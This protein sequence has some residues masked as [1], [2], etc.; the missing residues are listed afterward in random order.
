MGTLLILSVIVTFVGPTGSISGG[1]ISKPEPQA[2]GIEVIL[3]DGQF[4]YG[5]N[6]LDFDM[7]AFLRANDSPLIEH[8]QALRDWSMYASVNP[9]V[10][11]TLIEM[12]SGLVTG[13]GG[14]DLD[15]PF[16]YPDLDFEAEIEKVTVDLALDFYAH[17]YSY[18]A[19]SNGGGR[20]Q[21]GLVALPLTH[22]GEIQVPGDTPSGS[23]A[24]L[25]RLADMPTRGDAQAMAAESLASEFLATYEALFPGDDPLDDSNDINPASPP[26]STLLQFPF[27]LGA[28][29]WFSGA[30][31]WNG[32]GYGPPYSSMDFG[33]A[34]NICESPPTHLWSVAAAWGVG[35]HPYGYSC[36]YRIS[37]GNG[38]ETSYYH[39][40]NVR[41]DGGADR[42]DPIGTIACET[43]AGGFATGPHVHFS[44]LYNGAYYDLQG[45]HLSGWRIDVGEG[46]YYG[47]F[48]ERDG[49]RLYPYNTVF[50]D[51]IP[52]ETICPRTGSLILYRNSGYDCGGMGQGEGY[53]IPDASGWQN[54][55]PEFDNRASAIN[56]PGGWSTRLYE[57]RFRGGASV[58]IHADHDSFSGDFFDGGA[59]PLNDRVSSL[60]VF[61]NTDCTPG[62]PDVVV[63]YEN[64]G[65]WGAQ[66]AWQ[67]EG[68]FNL[69][70]HLDNQTSSIWVQDGWSAR[71]YAEVNGG[72]QA[73]CLATS[74]GDFA[75]NRY[76]GGQVVDDTASS[77]AIYAQPTCPTPPPPPT[78]MNPAD[79][80]SLQGGE[81][82]RLEWSG[83]PGS[84]EHLVEL[85]GGDGLDTSSGWQGEMS[86]DL[87]ALAGGYYQWRA[88]SRDLY[89]Q[90]SDWSPVRSFI[91]DNP[92]VAPSDFDNDQ[93]TD[94]SLFRPSNGSW[95]ILNRVA[96]HYGLPGDIPVAADYNGDGQADVAVFRPS[97]GRW[98]VKDLFTRSWGLPGD[99]P[100]PC[101]FDGDGD[102]DLAVYRPSQGRWSIYGQGT[103]Y[104][105]LEGD[106]PVPADYD[107]DGMCEIA[108]YR[109]SNGGWYVYG[110][111]VRYYGLENDLPVPADYN[112]DGMAE[113]AVFRPSESRWYVEGL[114][115]RYWGL[116]GDIPVPGNYDGD[117]DTDIAV[118]RPAQGRWY[119]LAQFNRYFGLA[120]DFPT[121]VRDTNADG[122]PYH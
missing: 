98:Y 8:L 29:W 34:G 84:S 111:P 6:A 68:L 24:V 121:M 61:E 45:T 75:D 5:P 4:V 43:C 64:P 50:N 101:D 40:L 27:P 104:W 79:G 115:Q 1:T 49:V 38:W 97:Q 120:G 53:F 76:P 90:E 85:W 47:G 69:P 19:R 42:N 89:L 44:L 39:L 112:G 21:E 103:Y 36:W 74:D 9:R 52:G 117:G 109:P 114:F 99:I 54:V 28:S 83:S 91:V 113:M 96:I 15:D 67:G 2:Q 65:Q 81:S 77:I 55:P 3:S 32:G 72:G 17:L 41:G 7:E 71:I 22:G 20:S 80:A 35:Y 11:L 102:A 31:S 30:H 70:A 93:S 57:D 26:P 23:A 92:Q 95:H 60:E 116:T 94:I 73:E 16:G 58:C 59:V 87:G 105:G 100:L 82:I 10:L 46:S 51:G 119:I 122:D 78:L 14:L 107:G 63:L 13:G 12:R 106:I 110:S 88:R 25:Q 48:I 56:I 37:H 18:G 118:Y 66:S 62:I 86:W 33:T 108:T